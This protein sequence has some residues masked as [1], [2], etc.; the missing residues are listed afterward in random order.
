LCDSIQS[1]GLYS[2]SILRDVIECRQFPQYSGYP[3]DP[4]TGI[5]AAALACHLQTRS[6]DFYQGTAMGRRSKISIAIPE[7]VEFN[8]GITTLICSGLVQVES[9]SLIEL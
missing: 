6:C 3:E 9:E 5:A 2:Y 1:T 4:A 8:T 7:K